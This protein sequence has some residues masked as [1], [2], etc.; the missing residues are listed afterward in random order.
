L[1]GISMVPALLG[2]KQAGRTQPKHEF[3]Y[4]EFHERGFEQAVRMD[5]WK[6]IRRP[7]HKDPGPE[8]Y[9]L[10]ND[11][12]ETKNVAAD[13]KEVVAKIEAYLKTARTEAKEWPMVPPKAA[14]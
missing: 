8:L 14:K 12:G 3:L 13:H 7:L 9:D 5:D 2:E 11:I 4:W 6:L 1:D 10:K